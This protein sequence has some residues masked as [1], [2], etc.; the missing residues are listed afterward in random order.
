MTESRNSVCHLVAIDEVREEFNAT[1][2]DHDDRVEEIWRD[3]EGGPD[4]GR[5]IRRRIVGQGAGP[6]ALPRVHSATFSRIDAGVPGPDGEPYDPENLKAL[7]AT[8]EELELR[9]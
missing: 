2:F 1:L 6:G 9:P 8:R 7:E 3:L 4:V 5:R